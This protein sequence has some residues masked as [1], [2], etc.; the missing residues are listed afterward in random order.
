MSLQ[1]ITFGSLSHIIKLGV[2]YGARMVM[3]LGKCGGRERK[4][5]IYRDRESEIERGVE[6]WRERGER[7]ER[8]RAILSSDLP[9]NY[10]SFRPYS[11]LP[12]VAV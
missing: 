9:V 7:R 12:P 5:E 8:E 1:L 6:R 4:K 2:E 10:F 11:Y 3:L